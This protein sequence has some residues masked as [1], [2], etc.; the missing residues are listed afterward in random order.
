MDFIEQRIDTV[1]AKQRPGDEWPEIVQ[2]KIHV[3]PV[4]PLNLEL[5]EFIDTI[6]TGKP[7]LVDGKVGLRA[8]QVALQIKSEIGL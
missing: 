4:Q 1:T 7:P 3:E 2:E 5:A 8:L 6:N